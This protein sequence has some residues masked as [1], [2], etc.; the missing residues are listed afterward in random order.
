[1]AQAW[2]LLAEAAD[3]VEGYRSI[4]RRDVLS[5]VRSAPRRVLDLG[6]GT[7]ATGALLKE[8]YPEAWVL[9]IE[10]HQASAREAAGRLDKVL[11]ARLE[12]VDLAAEGVAPGSIDLVVAADVLEHMVD[13]WAAL[14]A[15]RPFL[16]PGGR[17]VA[18]LPNVRNLNVVMALADKGSWRYQPEGILDVTHLRFFTRREML[19][20]FEDSGYRVR[21][22]MFVIDGR[23]EKL[24]AENKDKERVHVRRGRVFLRDITA[25]ELKELCS[26]QILLVAAPAEASAEPSGD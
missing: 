3:P 7:G 4:A 6:C 15:L 19:A 12:D 18:S 26:V 25:A 13:P 21:R 23:L 14:R 1:M 8:T 20:M 9:G 16:S 5:L 2:R 10:P 22:Q 11:A 24:Y 17:I